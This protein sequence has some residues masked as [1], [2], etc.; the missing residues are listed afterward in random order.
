MEVLVLDV[1][2]TG[3][4]D[5]RLKQLKFQPYVIQFCCVMMDLDTE[6][7]IYRY[8]TFVRP[9]SK[10]HLGEKITEVTRITWDTLNE[11]LAFSAYAAK[12]KNMIGEARAVA[13]HN[14][15]FDRDMLDLEAKRLGQEWKWPERQICTVELTNHM[16][17]Y[18]LNLGSLYSLLFNKSFEEAH[19]ARADVGA[20]CQCLVEMRRRDWL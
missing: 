16:T 8:D 13:A 1:E 10:E 9:P 5:S 15:V 20:L 2:T 18:R 3:L 11:H 19:D 7:E 14:L 12:I 17:G 6:K 4:I